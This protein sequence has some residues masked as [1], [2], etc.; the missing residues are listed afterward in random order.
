MHAA[1]VSDTPPIDAGRFIL[2]KLEPGD[3]AALFPT[4]SDEAQCRY[5]SRP[6]FTTMQQLAEWLTDPAWS[7]RS[8]VAV[9]KADRS[10][11]GRF[12]ASPG[13]DPDVFEVGYITVAGRQGQ[14]VAAECMAALISHLFRNEHCRRLFA[15]IDAD[16]AA[17]I[18]LVERLGFVREGRLREHETTHNGLCDML[19]YGLLQ[20]EWHSRNEAAIKPGHR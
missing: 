2:R 12:V 1:P 6:R 16:N 9:D 5:L 14:G 15:E 11:G 20:R 3:T 19:I 10:I 13:R 17:S 18:A 4:L 7:G 8:W